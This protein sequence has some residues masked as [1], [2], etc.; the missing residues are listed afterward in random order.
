[1][2]RIG[3]EAEK[4]NNGRHDRIRW[5]EAD[6]SKPLG[7]LPLLRDS[8]DMAMANWVFDHAGTIEGL[9][10]MWGNV[11]A[12]LKPGG[13]F[14]GVR[15][16]DLTNPVMAEIKYGGGRLQVLLHAVYGSS[17]WVRGHDDGADSFRVDEDL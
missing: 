1:M 14:V 2:L 7:H 8:Y 5:L 16:G 11:R 17:G 13:R 12:Y 4:T 3:E 9:E 15:G 10:G 6:V